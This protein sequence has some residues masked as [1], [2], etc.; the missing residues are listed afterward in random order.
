MQRFFCL[1]VFFSFLISSYAQNHIP[2]YG[3]ELHST[4]ECP[5]FLR[6]INGGWEAVGGESFT[7][8]SKGDKK[9]HSRNL[10]HRCKDQANF[11]SIS[12][13]A[14]IRYSTKDFNTDFAP[15]LFQVELKDTLTRDEEYLIEYY[16]RSNSKNKLAVTQ[17][18]DVCIFFLKHKYHFKMTS[19]SY[20]GLKE[21]FK[22]KPDIFF[23]ENRPIEDFLEWRK[24]SNRY[25]AKGGEKYFLIGRYGRV[26]HDCTINLD[27]IS[28][29]KTI[30]NKINI[31]NIKVGEAVTI[32]DIFFE[33]NSSILKESS[34]PT[35]KS[36]VELFYTYPNLAVEIA[37]HTDSIGDK[38]T[39][40]K[41]S[42]ER[43]K[44]VVDY[45]ISAGVESKRVQPKGYGE[46]S[47][48]IDN[49]TEEGRKMN[50]RVEF[51]ILQR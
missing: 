8:L 9:T 40:L 24:V 6:D 1:L 49:T 30:E 43:A 42:E 4:N 10:I 16:I 31:E 45:L 25:V 23:Y 12:G 46:S 13:S 2:N 3:F 20:D 41:L 47:P 36:I 15:E 19:Y 32:K 5:K 28:I 29:Q 51:K 14:Y 22:I 18:N 21:N 33:L 11:D 44:S 34:Y 37:G 27:N 48:T 7:S 26:K 39:N 38:N 35:L 17:R 50:R